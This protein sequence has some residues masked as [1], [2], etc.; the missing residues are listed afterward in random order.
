M[1]TFES[2]LDTRAFL[3][4]VA[5]CL[6][7]PTFVG[8]H[9]SNGCRSEASA[10]SRIQSVQTE[11][12]ADNPVRISIEHG[13]LGDGKHEPW[14]EDL[15]HYA[16]RSVAIEVSFVWS[17]NAL[18]TEIASIIYSRQYLGEQITNSES[19]EHV[20]S[21]GI[22]SKLKGIALERTKKDLLGLLAH[23]DYRL[24]NGIYLVVLWDNECIPDLDRPLQIQ[25]GDETELMRTVDSGDLAAVRSLVVAGTS[26]RLKDHSGRTALVRA[27]DG[28]QPEIAL[29]LVGAGADVN[30]QDKNGVSPLMHAAR[31][32]MTAIVD[33]LLL[34]GAQV[35]SQDGQG[36]TALMEAAGPNIPVELTERLLAAGGDPNLTDGS[37]MTALMFAA[38]GDNA[39]VAKALLAAGARADAKSK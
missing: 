21:S 29:V 11:L 18:Q 24:A 39:A 27:I 5:V 8:A 10:R 6:A 34:R 19:L 17:N 3:G 1:K 15:Q 33:A 22:D 38:M 2:K 9:Q 28:I 23:S 16:I 7:I 32:G 25:D 12:G 36:T 26:Q 4:I 20:R 37:D 35:N 14:M 31:H 30:D 13:G